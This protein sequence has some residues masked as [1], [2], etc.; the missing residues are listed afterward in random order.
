MIKEINKQLTTELKV[1]SFDLSLLRGFPNATAS[2]RD[3]VVVGKFGEG[4]LE[5]KT[6]DFHFRLLSLFGS[7]VKV[8]SI[9]IRDGALHA[10]IDKNGK[11]N[12]DIFK[13]SE[14]EEESNFSISLEKARLENIELAYQNDKLK[15]EMLMLVEKADFS[16]Q[17]SNEQFDLTSQADLVSN[18]IDIN[19]VRYLPGKHWGYDANIFVDMEKGTYSFKKVK[20]KVE[21]NLYNVEGTVKSLKNY[22]EYDLTADAEDANL[23]S[24]IALLPEEQ[25]GAFG[26]FTS[27]GQFQ[28]KAFINGKWSASEQPSIE[29]QFGLEDGKVD[30]PRLK[31]PFKDVSFEARFTNGEQR[32]SQNSVFEISNFKGYLNRELIT[33]SLKIEG[34]DK[35]YVDF[36]ADGAL[37]I[38]YMYGLLN[39]PGITDG[40]GEVEIK[41]LIVKG[42][43]SD[44]TDTRNIMAVDMGGEINFDDATLTINGE[45][46][47]V[48][49][50]LLVFQNNQMRLEGLKI[51]GAGSEIDLQGQAQNLLPVLFADSLN[52]KNASLDFSV[53][54]VSPKM[55]LA[56]LVKLADSPADSNTVQRQVYDSLQVENTKKQ[57]RLTDLLNGTFKAKVDEFTYNKIEGQGFAG[58]LVFEKGQ[59]KIAGNAKGME[60]AFELDGTMFFEKEPRLEAKLDGSHIDVKEFFRQSEN[61]GQ[62]QLTYENIEGTMNTK[63]LIHAFWDSTGQFLTDELHVW[64]GLGIQNGQLKGFK[65]LDE[66]SN[67]VDVKDLRDVRFVDMQN[68]IEVKNNTFYLPAMFIQNNA[69]NMTVSGEQTFDDKIDYNIKVNAG[70][71]IANKFKKRSKPEIIPAKQN[72]FFNLYFNIH[73][74]LDQYDY[75]TNKKKVK[76]N[77]SK[78]DKQKSQIRAALIR[79]FGAPLNMLREPTGWEDV[80]EAAPVRE[81]DDVEY[82]PGF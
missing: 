56:R 13:P 79:A 41:N 17:F 24:V 75:E 35:P 8:H 55:D 76:D 14:S 28:L 11:T 34:M 4:L 49:R 40:S 58:S 42:L 74:T 61:F 27:A 68:W 7:N 39:N 22:T 69:M 48:D 73:G 12:Y 26:D 23:A 82:I 38:G 30:S 3:V 70:Q 80:G 57:A 71:V 21:D 20:L 36:E 2:L 45:K 60:G 53:D 32:N 59:M 46:M 54:L 33:L 81:E 72:G 50:G 15:Q 29:F 51:D 37:P 67:Y 62:A 9:T 5:A 78:S 18:F 52:S 63:M 19:G 64:A 10:H 31:E 43:Y 1:G 77:L 25:L 44:M 47:I 65:L 16:G 66:F 6:M